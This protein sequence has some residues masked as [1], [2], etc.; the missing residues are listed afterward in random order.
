MRWLYPVF[1]SAF[2]HQAMASLLVVVRNMLLPLHTIDL[3]IVIVLGNQRNLCR[4]DC[5]VWAPIIGERNN[6][7]SC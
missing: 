3:L 7:L 6:R 5:V 4:Q 2:A 1:I